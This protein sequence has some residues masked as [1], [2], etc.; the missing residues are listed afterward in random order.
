MKSEQIPM[1][2][3]ITPPREK[4]RSHA[5]RGRWLEE[6]CAWTHAIYLRDGLARIDRNYPESKQLRADGWAR[7]IGKGVCDYSG[8]IAGGKAV[9]FDAK[10]CGR[11]SIPLDALKE[12]QLDHL[13]DVDR[14]GGIAF[15]LV[16][17]CKAR[18]YA[19]P[20]EHWIKAAEAAGL[21]RWHQRADGEKPARM[22]IREA[23]IP[24]AWG[25]QINGKGVDWLATIRLWDG[26]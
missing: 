23:D 1:I 11:K 3:G 22:S 8:V 2:P 4:S 17:F 7:V 14:L 25:V 12:H 21:H 18:A 15:V 24:S 13:R 26:L 10:E 16:A 5:N 20:A 6:Y 19:V 9:A